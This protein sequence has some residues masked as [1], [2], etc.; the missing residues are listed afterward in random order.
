M[1][2]YSNKKLFVKER[3][4]EIRKHHARLRNMS[5]HIDTGSPNTYDM[6]TYNKKKI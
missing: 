4:I 1:F 5:A 2:P 6:P 3:N